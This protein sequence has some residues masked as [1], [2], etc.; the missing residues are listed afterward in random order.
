MD[1]SLI[2][3]RIDL[4]NLCVT[5]ELFG[6][7][8]PTVA[9]EIAHRAAGQIP[10]LE[11]RAERILPP[12]GWLE[13]H[14]HHDLASA[15]R[16][17]ATSSHLP[18][19]PWI[20]RVRVMLAMS[21]HRVDEALEILRAAIRLDPYSPWLQGRMS[22]ALHLNG[23]TTASVDHVRQTW[24][25]FREPEGTAMYGAII[26]AYNGF[27][28]EAVEMA[29]SLA[30]RL[31]YFD[32]AISVHAYALACAGRADEAHQ[33]LERLQ[34]LSRERY[35]MGTFTAAAWVAL[36]DNDAAMAALRASEQARCPWFFQTLADPRLAPLKDNAE[37][38][39]MNT[40]V[41]RMEADAEYV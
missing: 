7:M 15:L 28:D 14:V 1:P 24:K 5:Q 31:P 33:M 21:R 30:Q 35:V 22:W 29:Q 19:D 16:L 40:I 41:E 3:A 6:F 36:N 4:V 20:T 25:S 23:D 8:S 10:N 27:A 17:Y 11:M 37:F 18:H 26:M 13:F 9:S 34:W 32:P 38:Q 39:Q 2:E 12:L